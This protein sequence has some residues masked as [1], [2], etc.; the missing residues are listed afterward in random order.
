M[1]SYLLAILLTT[2][3]GVPLAIMAF[4]KWKGIGIETETVINEVY[5]AVWIITVLFL[6]LGGYCD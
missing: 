3:L 2:G 6:V 1:S 4:C 5:A